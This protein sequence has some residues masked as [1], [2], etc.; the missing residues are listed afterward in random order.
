MK[1]YFEYVYYPESFKETEEEVTAM[2][3]AMEDMR[4]DAIRADR[5]KNALK[6]LNNPRLSHEDVALYS[7]LSLDEVKELAGEKSA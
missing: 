3:K 1:E 5:V 6:M 7:G 2:C 4:N